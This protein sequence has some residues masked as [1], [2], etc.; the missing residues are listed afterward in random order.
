MKG[1]HMQRD[2][3]RQ[4]EERLGQGPHH[5]DGLNGAAMEQGQ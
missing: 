5:G 3:D 2:L 4:S 1:D